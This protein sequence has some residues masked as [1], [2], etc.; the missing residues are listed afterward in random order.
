MRDNGG[1]IVWNVANSFMLFLDSHRRR[2][3]CVVRLPFKDQHFSES[4]IPYLAVEN[5]LSEK[6]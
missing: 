3:Y 5:Q 6:C 4:W 1:G 2:I